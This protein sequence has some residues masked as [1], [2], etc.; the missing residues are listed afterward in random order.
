MIPQVQ[1]RSI[2]ELI[3]RNL[4]VHHRPIA[5]IVDRFQNTVIVRALALNDGNITKTA[6]LLQAHR[7][8]L[9]H[10]MEKYGL[11]GDTAEGE[12]L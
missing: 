5:E 12:E 8:T 7:S 1:Q 6:K 10:W 11:R 3:D 9:V 4:T 2:E